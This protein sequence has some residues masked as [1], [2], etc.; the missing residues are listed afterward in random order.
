MPDDMFSIGVATLSAAAT[1]YMQ[2]M[3]LSPVTLPIYISPFLIFGIETFKDGSHNSTTRKTCNLT[4]NA[5]TAASVFGSI[6]VA[7]G[8]RSLGSVAI[9]AIGGIVVGLGLT[10]VAAGR[11]IK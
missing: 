4:S 3:A 1:A 9:Y 10:A 5:V 11:M 6:A 7:T 8:V 2:S